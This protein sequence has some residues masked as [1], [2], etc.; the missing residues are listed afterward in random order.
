[1]GAQE[2]FSVPPGKFP[3]KALVVGSDTE[4]VAFPIASDPH[5]SAASDIILHNFMS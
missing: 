2:V 4:A 3:G 5:S 1:L